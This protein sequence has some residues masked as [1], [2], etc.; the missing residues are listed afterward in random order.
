MRMRTERQAATA[1]YTIMLVLLTVVL[2]MGVFR[3]AE[4]QVAGG[5]ILGSVTDPSGAA[6]ASTQVT[7][8]NVAT[9][10]TRS[11]PTNNDGLYAAPNLVPGDYEVAVEA[12]GFA[13]SVVGGIG[14]TVGESREINVALKIG[15]N[16]NKITV[17]VEISDVQLESS[18]LG[19]VVDSHTVVD[20]PLNGR[21][22]TSLTLLEA[23][24]AQIS[25]QKALGIGND[26][27][28]RGL[29]VDITIGGNRPQGNNYRLDG[30]SIND[31]TSGAPGS[32]TGGVMGV[33]AV[34]EFSVITS[35]APADYGKTSGGVINAVSRSGANT[36]HGSAYEFIRNN[37]FDAL[38]FFKSKDSSGHTITPPFRR[39]QF[40]GSVGGPV[41]K[42]HT[43]FFADYEGLRQSLSSTSNITVPT[44]TAR[45]GALIGGTVVVNP[46]VAPFL[47]CS[48][49]S[50]LF[51]LPNG[52]I[53]GDTGTYSF[54]S[55]QPTTED[56][57]TGRV[58]HRISASDS[59][60]GSYVFDKAQVSNPDAYDIKVNGN[61][62]RRHTVAIEESHVLTPALLSTTRFGFNRDVVIAN[63]TLSAINPA[64]ANLAFGFDPGRPAGIITV[65]SGVS[66]FSGGLGAIGEYHFHYNSFQF[67]EDL[68]WAHNK[69]SLKVGFSAERIHDNQFTRGSSPNGFYT[70]GSLSQ[71]LTNNPSSFAT[72]LGASFTPRD[73]R[74]TLFSGYVQDDYKLLSNLTINAGV[75]YEMST[76]PT[77]TRNQLA[78]LVDFTD[79][80]PR[81]GSPYF[82]NPTL[83]NF[84]PRVGFSWDPF[85]T[86]KTTFRGAFG[87][88][89]VLPLPYQF[90]LL[91]LL[92]APFTEGGNATVVPGDFPTL[93]YAKAAAPTRLR[94]GYVQPNPH[95][96]YVEQWSFNIQRELFPSF[97]LTTGYVGSHGV[98]LPYHTDDIND[99]QPAALTA[100]GYIWPTTVGG[101]PRLFTNTNVQ[102]QVSANTWTAVSTYHALNVE[103][104]KRLSHGVQIQGSYTFAKSIDTSSSGIAGDTFGNSVSSL[105]FFDPRLRR[106]LSDFDN[107]HVLAA[108]ALWQIPGPTSWDGAPKWVASGWQIGGIFTLSGGLPFTPIIGGDPLG[109]SSADNY[110]FPNRTAGCNAVDSNFKRDGLL[111]LH[112]NCFTL[113]MQTPAIAAQCRLF[114]SIAGTCA[115]LLG[116]GGRNSVI[117]PGVRDL[118]FSLF[119]NNP[120]P[121]ISETFNVQFRWEIFNI[122]NH[123]NFEPPAPAA[124][125]IFTST[126]ALNPTAGLLSA[127]STNSRQMQFALKFIW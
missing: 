34:K 9:G 2:N 65:G 50:C 44:A 3:T 14:L 60:L 38:N 105:P 36:I 76:V 81:I 31:Y 122:A 10:V 123:A 68:Y 103:A 28:N 73:L 120:I 79:A 118:D 22:W 72:R 88:Y 57:A 121:W 25:T 58:D 13:S 45:T 91:T 39:N 21:D 77:E 86:G 78:T 87:M 1:V 64:A 89:D 99:I 106:G 49:S 115:N 85:K 41:I 94:Y 16:T 126:G 52:T 125:Q 19:N 6:V 5:T 63:S 98:H 127:T 83:R 27:P 92:S 96:S 109:L 69:H 117:G 114:G 30:V 48:A 23:G 37:A 15:Q 32:I 56:F 33:D 51:P 90:E 80:G 75:R 84:A 12:A 47:A 116:N 54:V 11:V 59:L 70:F 62:S 82:S 124:R 95:R 66:Q 24:V 35:N 8:K 97:T 102:G 107:R 42:D 26:R 43:F 119:K 74:Q 4:A 29:G 61:Q 17:A 67:Y 104:I 113:P 108:N 7:I 93:A 100:A 71:F 20:L 46:L 53:T 112:P 18:A 55:K 110:A 111:Y 40:G 101:G